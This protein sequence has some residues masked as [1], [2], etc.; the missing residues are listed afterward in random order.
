MLRSVPNLENKEAIDKNPTLKTKHLQ[1]DSE[2]PPLGLFS[3]SEDA[4]AN[5]V[6]SVSRKVMEASCGTISLAWRHFPYPP[7][8]GCMG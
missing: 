3:M 2:N 4:D 6:A 8:N 5:E 7:I 1:K